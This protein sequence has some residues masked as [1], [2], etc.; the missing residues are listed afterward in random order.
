MT[1]AQVQYV[2]LKP[3]PVQDTDGER[4]LLAPGDVL[5]SDLVGSWVDM[6]IEGGKVAVLAESALGDATDEELAAEL[7]AR[8]YKVTKATSRTRAPG[9]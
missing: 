7:S 8:G 6:A 1:V 4:L 5:P 2:A 3:L 9:A